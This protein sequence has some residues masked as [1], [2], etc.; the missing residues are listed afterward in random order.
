VTVDTSG[1]I[2]A[3]VLAAG[4]GTRLRPLTLVRAK[5]AIPVAGEP[6]VRRIVAGLVAQG[7][8]DIVVNLHHRPETITAVLGDGSDLGARVRYSW[9]YPVVLGSA[10]GPRRALDIIGAETFA[11]VNG[12]TLTD[13]NLRAML[14]Q[15]RSSRALVTLALI[16]NREPH[17]YNGVRL[18]G[19]SRVLGFVPRGAAAEGSFHV[20][21]VQMVGADVFRGL[22]PGEPAETIRGIYDALIIDR[23]GSVRG[24]VSDAAFWDVGTIADYWTTSRALA[25][26]A[27]AHIGNRCA[28]DATA[29]LDRSI[30]WDHVQI[31]PGAVIE[32]SIVTDGV[33]VPGG[34]IYRDVVVMAGPSGEPVTEPLSS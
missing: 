29:R 33:R 30:V 12:D 25:G 28:I 3:L 14:D 34:A 21:G 11:I 15:H 19:R 18:D 24:F 13:V 7:F 26:G 6:L 20:I 23:P 22:R 31:G 9:E 17:R 4:L 2:P 10:G 16:P 32:R 27:S 8:T 5:A 1:G